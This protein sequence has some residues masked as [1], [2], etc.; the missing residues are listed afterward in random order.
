MEL[1]EIP[2]ISSIS[3]EFTVTIDDSLYLIR[4]KLGKEYVFMDIEVDNTPVIYGHVCVTAV[5]ILDKLMWVDTKTPMEDP[6][7]IEGGVGERWL[8]VIIS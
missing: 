3:Q 1:L 5:P 8:L 4:I 7:P 6:A 2:L